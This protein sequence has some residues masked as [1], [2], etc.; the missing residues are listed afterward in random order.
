MSVNFSANDYNNFSAAR[1]I[2]LDDPRSIIW[3]LGQSRY[4]AYQF[5]VTADIPLRLSDFELSV[6]AGEQASDPQLEAV[7]S[8][9]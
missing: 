4:R 7:A 8:Q 5:L 1:S 6:Q 9:Q 2:A 3:Q